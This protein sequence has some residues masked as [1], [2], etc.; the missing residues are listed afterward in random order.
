[1]RTNVIITDDFY[2]NPYQVRE[3]ALSQEFSVTGNY[4]G[5][6]TKSFLSQDVKD[7][8]QSIVFNAG[9]EVTNWNHTDGFTGS[10]QLTTAAD[11][12]WIH[13]DHNNT[14]AGVC[15][16][17]PDAPISGGTGL[18]LHKRTGARYEH[19]LTDEYESQDMTRWEMVDRIGNVFNR[20]VMY[21]SD[22]FHSSLDYF[23]KNYQDG[24][25]FQLFFFDTQF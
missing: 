17:T 12:S 22:I 21:R 14:W 20:L 9:G 1:M 16:L 13:T 4:P 25:L 8:I 19:Q 23:G 11:R 2:S 24:R 18:F 3:F 15:Y 6:R 5:A 7:T 10:F